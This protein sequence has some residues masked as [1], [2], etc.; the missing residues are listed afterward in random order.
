VRVLHTSDW[1]VGRAV[2]GRNRDEEHRAV[3]AEMADLVRDEGIDLVLVAGDVFDHQ[4]PSA[5][6]EEIVYEALLRF[7]DLGVQV[8]MIAGNH[9]HPER[10]DAVRPLL[11]LANIHVG[12]RLRRP[13][14][15]GCLD[16]TVRSGERARVALMPWPSRSRIVTADELMD[17]DREKH[18][19]KYADI[20]G[21][22]LRMLC[23]GFSAETVNLVLA[24]L[25]IMRSMF[26]GGERSSEMVEEYW[27]PRE[28][29]NLNAHYVALG[30]IH[31]QQDLRLMWPAWYCGSPL[32]L[33]FGEEK[34]KKGVLLFEAKAG[35]AVRTPRFVELNAGRRMLTARGTLQQ[36]ALRADND[37]FGDAYL[38]VFV[39]EPARSGLAE[40]VR[41]LLPN[42][43]EVKIEAPDGFEGTSLATRE[44][45]KPR[46]VIAAYFQHANV[47]D[48]AVLSLFDEL[49]EEENAAPTA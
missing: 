36:L 46:E 17:R 34:D 13:E 42:A 15:G 8:V 22:I 44:G 32:Q 35:A 45:L 31:Q 9:D 4:S 11:K 38:R 5:A 24:H 19:G 39:N 30:H 49:L 18:Q 23:S 33:D 10:L 27:V 21:Q 41:A 29:L 26:G 16:V 37:D 47:K 6:A 40:E 48:D 2:R 25:V 28:T 12:A 1:H 20:C 3:F 43:V 7:S 14:E